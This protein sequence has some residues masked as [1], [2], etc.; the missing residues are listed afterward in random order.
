V[1]EA[2]E[3]TI[4]TACSHDCGGR[5]VLKVHVQDGVIT[6]IETDGGAEP[7]LR[8]CLRG[9]SYRQRVYASDRLKYPMKRVGPRGEGDFQ[10]I[11]WDEALDTVSKELLRVRDTYGPASICYLGLSGSTTPLHGQRRPLYRLFNMFGGCTIWWGAASFEGSSFASR[12]TLG[13][14]TTA[15]TRDDLRNSRLIILWGHNPANTVWITNTSH[16]LARAREAGVKIISVDPRYTDSTATFAQQW[17]PIRPGTDAALLVAMAYVIIQENLQDQAFLDKYTVGFDKFKDY[18]LGVEDGQP[19]APFWAEAITGVP[20]ATIETLAR[21]YA[22][23]KPA[24]L[25]AGWGPGRSANGEQF[26]RAA[27]TLAA[28]TGNIGIHGGNAAGFEG[29]PLGVLGSRL[30][31][32]RSPLLSEP[33]AKGLRREG[34][35]AYS[36]IDRTGVRVHTSKVFEAILEGTAGGYPSDIKLLY[37]AA[38]NPVNQ[39]PHTAKII[40]ALKKVDFTVVHEQFMTY[41]ARF[42]DILLPVN[43][44]M[45]KIDIGEPWM[46]GPWFVYLDKAIEPL[47]ESKSDWEICRE[48]APRLGIT[49]YEEKSEEAWLEGFWQATPV[50]LDFETFKQRGVHK[51][52]LAEPHVAFK[53]QIEDPENHP[54]PTPSGRIE[55]YSQ[56]LA[57]MNNPLLPPV[58]KYVEVWEGLND[59]LVAKYP[60][61]L[62]STHF[63]TR[64]HSTFV[65]V[66]WLAE[67]EPQRVWLNPADA[68]A[69]G[70]GDGDMVRI[71][72]DRGTVVLPARVTGRIMPGVVDIPEGAWY[73]PDSEG[74]DRGGSPNTLLRDDISPAGAFASNTCLVQAEKLL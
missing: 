65:K 70:I 48:L 25:L 26:H 52:E 1:T 57:D 73:A 56:Q 50:V 54:F 53:E 55:I 36:R 59:P 9:R 74:I 43:T 45:E 7:Q 20:A 46:S 6:R 30:P 40:E 67:L 4:I 69:R 24:A 3:K 37:V 28:M 16:Y 14:T 15:N 13:S 18:V 27:I 11:S 38:C 66:P 8:A 33:E 5:C 39:F 23:T 62:I 63:K 64:D 17:I 31:T 29:T 44:F 12:I 68:L 19:K 32:G 51:V 41:T 58:P 72:N 61:Q 60:L 49:G 47:Y 71:F 35:N 2:G 22:T 34:L 21:E 42:A 10:R